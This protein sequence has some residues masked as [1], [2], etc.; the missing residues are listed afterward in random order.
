MNADDTREHGERPLPSAP[1]GLLLESKATLWF[2]SGLTILLFAITNLPWQL[3]IHSQER[4]AL[5]SFQIVKQGWWFYQE[6]P[7]SRRVEREATKPPL[8]PWISVGLYGV[9]RSWDFAWR[10]P[11]FAA[12]IAL[13]ILLFRHARDAF[14]AAA[15]LLALSALSFNM[16]TPR[17]AT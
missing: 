11:A 5:A 7:R 15:G 9:T 2:V 12:A 4:Q 8:I 6:A 16:L 3:D 10:L 13:A 1:S 17:I 14:G